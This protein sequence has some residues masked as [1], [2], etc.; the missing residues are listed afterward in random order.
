MCL[1]CKIHSAT[2]TGAKESLPPNL[3]MEGYPGASCFPALGLPAQPGPNVLGFQYISGCPHLA[4]AP[5]LTSHIDV[6]AVPATQVLGE[7]SQVAN[8]GLQLCQSW[9]TAWKSW[10]GWAVH[11]LE[12]TIHMC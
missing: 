12:F 3:V 5:A 2:H 1:S 11:R 10:A 8:W 7:L 4:L 6:V 9:W